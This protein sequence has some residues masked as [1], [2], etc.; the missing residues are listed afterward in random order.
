MIL[1]KIKQGL[2]LGLLVFFGSC[3]KENTTPPLADFLAYN[4]AC[5]A[6][7]EVYFFDN[8]ERAVAWS[9]N[10]GDGQTSTLENDTNTYQFAGN[11][12]V[13]LLVT[14]ENG[15]TDSKIKWITVLPADT[16][17][18]SDIQ[19]LQYKTLTTSWTEWD[20]DETSGEDFYIDIKQNGNLIY[21]GDTVAFS[22]KSTA[23]LPLSFILNQVFADDQ[24]TYEI[25]LYDK[26]TLSANDFLGSVSFSPLDYNNSS[27]PNPPTQITL[28]SPSDSLIFQLNVSWL[29]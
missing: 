4:V 12:K 10:F 6:P 17:F 16:M 11:Y 22:N 13:E 18:V 14:A 21:S 5:V 28:E 2:A 27:N 19:L 9:W 3:K 7:C 8:S 24:G 23:D 20:L 1:N 15:T 29:N 25:L 26:D